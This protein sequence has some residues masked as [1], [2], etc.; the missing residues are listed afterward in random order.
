MI[1]QPTRIAADLTSEV[2]VDTV[3][4]SDGS[5]VVVATLLVQ[6]RVLEAA[7]KEANSKLKKIEN[8][9]DGY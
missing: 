7:L 1:V 8:L 6:L 3:Y 2:L 9:Q 4:Y 5:P